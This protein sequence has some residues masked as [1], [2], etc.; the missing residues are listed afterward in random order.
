MT[1]S[2]SAVSFRLCGSAARPGNDIGTGRTAN[3][4]LSRI[5]AEAARASPTDT[6]AAATSETSAHGQP[7]GVP[8]TAR[9]RHSFTPAR[10]AHTMTIGATPVTRMRPSANWP[11]AS[12]MATAGGTYQRAR[13]ARSASSGSAVSQASS[14]GT[15]LPK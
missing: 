15:V 3:P 13:P 1:S 11:H 9:R 6:T 7:P 2:P 14:T 10:T 5:R 12:T 4:P 8:R